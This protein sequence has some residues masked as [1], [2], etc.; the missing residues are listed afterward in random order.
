MSKA[1]KINDEVEGLLPD[2]ERLREQGEAVYESA[3]EGLD[4]AHEAVSGVLG[5]VNWKKVLGVV[6]GAA[7]VI[8]VIC[9]A[10]RRP[11]RSL[12]KRGI[13]EGARYAML[14]PEVWDKTRHQASD[15]A[16]D[17]V[18][19]STRLWNKIPRVRVEFK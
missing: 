16:H 12:L 19:E 13:H 14:V 4:E 7:V 6:A 2:F 8:G 17:S 3:R 18:R 15:L 5:A 10:R 9:L 1:T 11:A